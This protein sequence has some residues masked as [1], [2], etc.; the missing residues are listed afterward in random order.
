M[1]NL[2]YKKQ[3]INMVHKN[4]KQAAENA[5]Y[6]SI[7][8]GTYAF[9]QVLFILLRLCVDWSTMSTIMLFGYC[10]LTGVSGWC[11]RAI[12]NT[13]ETARVNDIRDNQ[14]GIEYYFDVYCLSVF[15]LFG[16][17]LISD[18]FWLIYL[19]IPGYVGFLGLKYLLNWVFTET[20]QEKQAKLMHML[21]AEKNRKKKAKKAENKRMANRGR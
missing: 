1:C 11:V 14:I 9:A 15:V 6:N 18:W 20:E 12:Y 2:D 8:F 4:K 19:S 13:R 17:A 16:V 7:L 3:K 21:N 10:C 5:T